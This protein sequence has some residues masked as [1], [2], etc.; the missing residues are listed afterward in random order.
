MLMMKYKSKVQWYWITEMS[1]GLLSQF[2]IQSEN[3]PAKQP[4][5]GILWQTD[6]RFLHQ[7]PLKLKAQA[8]SKTQSWI[9]RDSDS[10][11]TPLGTQVQ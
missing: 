3:S 5:L 4:V 7:V 8:A 1:W 10:S 9:G 6:H 2:K 11:L